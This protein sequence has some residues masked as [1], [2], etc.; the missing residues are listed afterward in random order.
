MGESAQEKAAT[1]LTNLQTSQMEKQIALQNQIYQQVSPY[2]QS[3]LALGENPADFANTAMGQAL[4]SSGISSIDK[5][6]Q[7]ALNNMIE[8]AG[9]SGSYGTGALAGPLAN[10]QTQAAQ[11][12]SNVNQQMPL[13]ALNLA[14]QGAAGLAGQ[15]QIANPLG[16]AG[17]AN[18][19]ASLL[20][21]STFF[22]TLGQGIAS[23]LGSF[24]SPQG[25]GLAAAL[26][27][28]TQYSKLFD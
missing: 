20:P 23:G 21:S 1:K 11:A 13:T 10:M 7:A 24:F 16:W 25:V 9:L 26:T 14:Q 8:S 2:Y 3:L 12:R 17:T 22:G 6:S 27:N 19:A 18:Q 4:L 15:Q 5:E 28:P